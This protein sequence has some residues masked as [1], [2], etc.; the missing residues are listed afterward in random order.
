M[1]YFDY[2][3]GI[4]DD[5]NEELEEVDYDEDEDIGTTFDDIDD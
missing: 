3:T 4:Y 1:T 2:E 5:E